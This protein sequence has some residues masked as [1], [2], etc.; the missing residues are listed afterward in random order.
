[1]NLPDSD[2]VFLRYAVVRGPLNCRVMQS[3]YRKPSTCVFLHLN[4]PV[5]DH[6]DGQ[7]EIQMEIINGLTNLVTRQTPQLIFFVVGV[8]LADVSQSI[9]IKNPHSNIY[10][11]RKH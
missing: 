10:R 6:S 5:S 4:V 8:C 11:I 9:P 2:T 3:F 7:S 1:M